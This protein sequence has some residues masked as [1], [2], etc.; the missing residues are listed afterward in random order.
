MTRMRETGRKHLLTLSALSLLGACAAGGDQLGKPTSAAE[1]VLRVAWSPPCSATPA[2]PNFSVDVFADGSVRF[3]GDRPARELGER[4]A[5]ISSQSVARMMRSARAVAEGPAGPSVK[6]RDEAAALYCL[7]VTVRG[8]ATL[9][10]TR[11]ASDARSA[12]QFIKTLDEVVRPMRWVCP[13]RGG[14]APGGAPFDGYHFCGGYSARPAI[15]YSI[16]DENGCVQYGGRVYR[17]VVY[18]SAG[19]K[20]VQ[21]GSVVLDDRYRALDAQQFQELIDAARRAHLSKSGIEEPHPRVD[22]D[23]FGGSEQ[24][25]RTFRQVLERVAHLTPFEVPPGAALCTKQWPWPGSLALRYEWGPPS[26]Q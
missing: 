5:Q 18:S 13:E 12:Q 25:L 11:V 8:G 14:T 26:P 20:T 6:S 4:R 9:H 16:A 23:Y 19:Y 24:D 10:E 2:P 17:N 7:D 22:Q 15:S 3:T 21:G 1:P